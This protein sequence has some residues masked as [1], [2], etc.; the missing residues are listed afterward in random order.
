MQFE[1]VKTPCFL[2]DEPALTQNIQSFHEAL[3]ANFARHI[4]GY[5]YK[6]NALPYILK[7]MQKLG[8]YAEVVSD[9]EYALAQKAGYA[10][11]HIIFNGPIKGEAC[12]LSALENGSIVNLDSQRE[13]RWLEAAAEKSNRVYRVGLRVNFNLNRLLPGETSAEDRGARFGYN[14]ENGQ[15]AAAIERLQAHKNI[16]IVGL[17]MHT[18]TKSH[19]AAIYQALTKKACSLAKAHNL[20]LTYLDIGGSFFGGGDGGKQYRMYCASIAAVLQEEDMTQLCLIVEPGASVI[21]SPISF[22]TQVLDCKS[23]DVTDFVVTNGSRVNIDPFMHK[24]RYVYEL[25]PKSHETA[26]EQIVCG[27]TCMENDRIMQLQNAPRLQ[28]NDYILYKIVGSYTMCF[29]PL[30]IEYFPRVYA[31]DADGTPRL[32]RE[33]WGV[34]EYC[35]NC[36]WE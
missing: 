5:S 30:F 22:L 32:V 23:T 11:E 1:Q 7:K 16:E 6:T 10:P 28:E 35:Q 9:T 20:P 25:F 19:S 29:N 3:E 21:A 31:V 18:S 34:E 17:H 36:F 15:L 2:I 12:F 13:L 8:C 33:Q 27:Y 4:I 26:A 24:T 14:V